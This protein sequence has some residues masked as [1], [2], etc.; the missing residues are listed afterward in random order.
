MLLC[1]SSELKPLAVGTDILWDSRRFMVASLDSE[2]VLQRVSVP[3]LAPHD[4]R[5]FAFLQ[6]G[7][8]RW[9]D[10]S[11]T[12][13]KQ[14]GERKGDEQSDEEAEQRKQVAG[15]VRETHKRRL[16]Q[17]EQELE[18]DPCR[19]KIRVSELVLRA[20]CPDP[21]GLTYIPV[22]EHA[23]VP[24]V[25]QEHEEDWKAQDLLDLG[26]VDPDIREL[27]LGSGYVVLT[28]GRHSGCAHIVWKLDQQ[29]PGARLAGYA[30]ALLDPKIIVVQGSVDE[31]EISISCSLLDR[32][33]ETLPSVCTHFDA[34]RAVW[35][36]TGSRVVVASRAK[37]SWPVV[38]L[39]SVGEP[40]FVW[41]SA[42]S[43]GLHD[44]LKVAASPCATLLAAVV[45]ERT[46]LGI[47]S[48]A[49]GRA[50]LIRW[51]ELAG[52][53]VGLFFRDQFVVSVSPEGTVTYW[54]TKLERV[55]AF[56]FG[57]PVSA[58]STRDDLWALI[59]EQR[60]FLCQDKFYLH[61]A[62]LE[63]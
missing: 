57:R 30:I 62:G 56:A 52:L 41:D 3:V 44:I 4:S 18:L 27:I 61:A 25:C 21:C 24:L 47:F 23:P 19:L 33:A 59:S 29:T 40:G 14:E 5:R 39:Y 7:A 60:L 22:P 1:G 36:S 45:S 11:V 31:Y 26:P 50:T 15:L 53:P 54:S 43:L 32:P 49:K 38:K 8:K 10:L 48:L 9:V 20:H 46:R 17:I 51:V 55:F 63:T 34:P 37:G 16:G 12:D 58:V 28:T 13:Q 35:S 2:S 42:W 6:E